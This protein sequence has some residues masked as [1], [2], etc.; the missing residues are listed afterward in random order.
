[1]IHPRTFFSTPAEILRGAVAGIEARARGAGRLLPG[2]RQG[3]RG[4]A[5]SRS[6]RSTTSR[7]CASSATAPAS[8]T[9]RATSAGRDAGRSALHAPR[10]FPRRFPDHHRRVPRHRPPDRRHV[11]RRPLPQADPGRARLPAALG[12][13]QPAPQ[14]RRVRRPRRPDPLRLGDAG[15][16]RAQAVGRPRHRAAHPADRPDRPGDRDPAHQGPG[17]RPHGRDPGPGRR[18]TSGRWSR[19]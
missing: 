12:P 16:V 1:M 2:P 5:R 7:C 15:P 9:T 4:R 19:P 13:R 18:R 8:R 17:R 6:G 11:L 10:L 3:R 14:L